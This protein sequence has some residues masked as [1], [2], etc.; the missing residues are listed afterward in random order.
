MKIVFVIG[1]LADTSGGAERVLR[2]ISEGLVA[3]GH[4]VTILS[5][6]RSQTPSRHAFSSAVRHH[7]LYSSKA[8]LRVTLAVRLQRAFGSTGLPAGSVQKALFRSRLLPFAA[9]IA[10]FLDEARPDLCVGFMGEGICALALGRGTRPTSALASLHSAPERLFGTLDGKARLTL[11]A[12]DGYDAVS[13]P[14][15]EHISG[16]EESVRQR[17]IVLPNPVDL[18]D[19]TACAQR[20]PVVAAVGRLVPLKRFDLLLGAWARCVRDGWMLEI[21]GEGPERPRLEALV[22]ANG[23]AESVVL[24]GHTEDVFSV[25][26]RT[27]VLVH[28]S[29]FEGFGLVLAE[30]MGRGVPVVGF[31][32]A[33]GVRS[34]IRDQVNGLLVAEP[35]SESGLAEAL[36]RLMQDAELR[37]RLGADAPATVESYRLENALDAWESALV[38]IVGAVQRSGG[39]SPSPRR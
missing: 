20:S 28:P 1:R 15:Q 8:P 19:G 10:R 22:R 2:D 37:A 23:L 26:R 18:G 31:A 29:R 21:H 17:A 35:G 33:P 5:H 11:D 36:T 6:S 7:N 3:R 12:L 13:F 24:A 32:D 16:M 14:L 4:E 25:Y 34:L 9:K 30:A 39:I 27:S 38:S